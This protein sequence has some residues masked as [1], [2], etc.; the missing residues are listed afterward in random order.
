MKKICTKC[1]KEKTLDSFSFKSKAKNTKIACCKDCVKERD[2][3][4]YYDD[5]TSFR[6]KRRSESKI[7]RERNMKFVISF[8]K[9]NPCIDCG[10]KNFIC[11][12]FDHRKQEDKLGIIANLVHY[13][14]LKKIKEEID[15]CD[16]RCANCHKIRTAK[17]LGYYKYID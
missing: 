14:S 11:L 8:L 9:T 16:V 4:R 17:Q 3:I 12:E 5:V 13:S 2:K 15:K 1:K 7:R 6:F 10:E